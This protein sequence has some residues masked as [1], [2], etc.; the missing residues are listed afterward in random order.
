MTDATNS[1]WELISGRQNLTPFRLI[2]PGP[3]SD[4]LDLLLRCAASAPDHG[5]LVPWHFVHISQDGRATLGE[6]FRLAL[7]ER[8]AAATCE[9]QKNALEKAFRAP[10]LLL[11]VL[12][13]GPR[14]K[15]IPAVEKSVS[16]GCAIQNM[17]L[18]ARAMGYGSGL[19]SGRALE[20]IALRTLF[21]LGAHEH[22]TC[23]VN[24]GTVTKARPLRERP[25]LSRILTTFPSA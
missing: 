17:L 3:S 24:F 21:G 10:C 15:P 6:A 23:F 7:L 18:M 12:D 1:A 25:A 8:D 19:S 20:S 2:A 14:E 5:E 13:L 9:Q 4:E 16:L 22:A 11:A